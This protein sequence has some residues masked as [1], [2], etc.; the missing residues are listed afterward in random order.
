ME[1]ES[2]WLPAR[3][4]AL[5]AWGRPYWRT[6]SDAALDLNRAHGLN[7]CLAFTQRHDFL[8]V[9]EEVAAEIAAHRRHGALPFYAA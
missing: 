5:C 9:L 7:T 1:K 8:V 2:F 4:G 6:L 3:Q